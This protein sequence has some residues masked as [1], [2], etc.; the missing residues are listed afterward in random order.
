[1]KTISR[2][3]LVAQRT[4]LAVLVAPCVLCSGCFS[5]MSGLGRAWGTNNG[6]DPG[7]AL[8]L[9]I[10]TAPVQ[11]AAL[12]GYLLYEM[13]EPVVEG[14]V[15]GA[16]NLVYPPSAQEA[17]YERKNALARIRANPSCVVDSAFLS[18][19]E[20]G[21]PTPQTLAF[22]EAL[23]NPDIHF[24]AEVL[25]G[26]IERLRAVPKAIPAFAPIFARAEL[27]AATL[28]RLRPTVEEWSRDWS[29]DCERAF[30]R[31]P[32]LAASDA[33]PP[34]PAATED[35]LLAALRADPTLVLKDSVFWSASGPDARAALAALLADEST[36]IP[37]RVLAFLG[38]ILLGAQP[39]A[40]ELLRV[41]DD[42]HLA[43]PAALRRAL[44]AE[45]A[46]RSAILDAEPK[47]L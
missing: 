20:D 14:V 10:V 16:V 6:M 19:S 3:H 12:A 2:I 36:E 18:L 45:L 8:M 24:P 7:A 33:P 30:L 35:T 4:A 22:A 13:A 39:D 28:E 5:I 27:D 26:A 31:N 38:T 1:M 17:R 29:R 46:R 44:A 34:E 21:R 41:D 37:D 9:D 43:D 42:G 32:N 25:D 40:A 15:G 47:D 11:I 23:R